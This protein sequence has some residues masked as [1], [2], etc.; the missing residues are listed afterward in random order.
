MHL[1]AEIVHLQSLGIQ[2]ADTLKARL[3]DTGNQPL[4]IG[5]S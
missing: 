5:S 1:K 2:H 4:L 3:A